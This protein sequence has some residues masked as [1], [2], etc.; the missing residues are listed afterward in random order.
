MT[1]IELSEQFK[2]SEMEQEKILQIF[3]TYSAASQ[4]EVIIKTYL[5]ADT[6]NPWREENGVVERNSY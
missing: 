2:N 5:S 3:D 1:I 6:T 4:Q